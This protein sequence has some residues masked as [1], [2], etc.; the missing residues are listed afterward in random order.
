MAQTQLV[1]VTGMSGAGKST[2]IRC[3]EDMGYFA[4]DNMPPSLLPTFVQLCAQQERPVSHVAA[5]IDVRGGEFFDDI[6]SALDE[7]DQAGAPYRIVFLDAGTEVLLSRFKEHRVRHPLQDDGRSLLDAIETERELLGEL[8]GRASVVL[9]TSDETPRALRGELSKLFSVSE[10][11]NEMLVHIISFGFKH[12]MPA[13]VDYVFDVR[14]LRNPHHDPQL[15][16]FTGDDPRVRAY[17]EEDPR[18]A[19]VRRR[20]CDFMDFVLPQHAEEGRRYVSI[21]VGC[22]GGKHRSRVVAAYL[23]E[24]L[25][26]NGYRVVRQHRD[27]YREGQGWG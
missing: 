4:I 9:D 12:G 6:V 2:A 7:L 23:A 24:H 18:T 20:L 14:Y 3:L 8:K 25:E 17:V 1:I 27:R 22:T 11:G 15:R 13:D 19:E 16:P 5:V 26:R 10:G 21:G